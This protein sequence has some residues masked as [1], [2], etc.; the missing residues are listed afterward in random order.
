MA[1]VAQREADAALRS[2]P[3]DPQAALR[4]FDKSFST[5]YHGEPITN[6]FAARRV[7][8]GDGRTI[9]GVP[10][11][12]SGF[13][14]DFKDS[15]SDGPNSDQTHHF[16]AYLS[17]GVNNDSG[18]QWL[19]KRYHMSGD[20]TGDQNLGRAAYYDGT[21]LRADPNRLRNI[22]NEIRQNICSGPGRGLN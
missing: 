12:G 17:L 20:N 5:L 1:D 15:G 21:Q 2:H 10:L 3:N 13:R 9:T 4:E 18:L 22:G 8:G 7:R 19:M 11:D 6:A 14:N 16:S